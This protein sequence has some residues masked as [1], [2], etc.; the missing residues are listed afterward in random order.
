M[1]GATLPNMSIVLPSLGG[2]SGIWDSEINDALGL[3]DVHDHSTGKGV[4]VPVAGLNINADVSLGTTYGLTNVNRISFASVAAPAT[5][6]SLYVDTSHNLIYRSNAGATVRITNGGQLDVA[7]VAGTFSGDFVSAGYAVAVDDSNQRYPFKKGSNWARGAFGGVQLAEFNTSE[8]LFVNLLAPAALG[9][10]YDL[11]F[12]TALPGS[13]QL[14]QVSSAGQLSYSNTVA[15]AVTLSGG[16]TIQAGATIASGA[17]ISASGTETTLTP[18][19][20]MKDWQ[21]RARFVVDHLGHPSGQVTVWDEHW[22]TAGTTMPE[23]WTRAVSGSGAADVAG[24]L[25]ELPQRRLELSCAGSSGDSAVTANDLIYLDN[26]R[27]LT[28]EATVRTHNGIV[29]SANAFDE[30]GF[31]LSHS[32]AYDYHIVFRATENTAQNW[33][34][35]MIGSATTNV[36]TTVAFTGST[37]YRLKLEVLGSTLTGLSAGTFQARFWINGTLRVTQ[38]FTTP[39]ADTIRPRIHTSAGTAAGAGGLVVGRVRVTFNHVAASDEI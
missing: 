27:A 29:S 24:P 10:S 32:G 1:P 22:R 38:T 8:T 30:I 17:A 4:R 15:A 11:T 39:G 31:Q 20:V 18:T 35:M 7:S 28:L 19:L 23:G 33:R 26:D 36:D 21:G 3:I 16:A 12:A 14:V 25:P 2:D 9:A 37:T 13:T 34:A 5:N 6:K